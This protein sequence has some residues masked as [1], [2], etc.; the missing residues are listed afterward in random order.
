MLMSCRKKTRCKA[1][2]SVF[3][4]LLLTLLFSCSARI[5]GTVREGGAAEIALK[6]SMEPAAGSVIRSIRAFLG[7]KADGPLLDGAAIAGSMAAA[8]GIRAVFLRNTGPS[9]IE[10]AVSVS[11][12]GN[13]LAEAGSATRFIAFTEGRTP[14]SS[15]VVFTLDKT[16]APLLIARL[17]PETEE[18]LSALMAPI[19][20]GEDST[21]Q[22]YLD[23]LS[24]VYGR[25]LA[26]ETASARILAVIGFPRP[27][28]AVS[29]GKAAGRNAEF[30]IPLL[31]VLVLEHP[32]RYEVKW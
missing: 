31:D 24:A 16:S 26:A 28:T 10:G 15:S 1:L 18:Y 9:G 21:R 2:I 22:E 7:E 32:L 3:P 12:V 11:N 8:P 20:L 17:S 29:G 19:V 13:F 25:A 6:A 27:V 23:L 5:D 30:D 4:A 14:G